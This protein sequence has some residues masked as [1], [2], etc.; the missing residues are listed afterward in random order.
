MESTGE[1]DITSLIRNKPDNIIRDNE[2]R[3]CQL[4]EVA[5]SGDGNVMKKEAEKIVKYKDLNRNTACVEC[6]NKSDTS[7]N[8]GHWNHLEIIQIIPEH[9]TGKA[10]N[11]GTADNSHIGHCTHTAES[12][13]VKVQNIQHGM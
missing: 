12:S 2:K 11:Q 4:I 3:T 6:K 5:V 10:Q 1:T 9:H 8:R 7:N 13:N